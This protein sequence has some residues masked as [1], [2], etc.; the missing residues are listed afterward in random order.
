[1][2]SEEQIDNLI[3]E[4]RAGDTGV[5]LHEYLGMTRAEYKLFVENPDKYFGR[6]Q[7]FLSLGQDG[8]KL[9]FIQEDSESYRK[10]QE[11]YADIM[12]EYEALFYTD[13]ELSG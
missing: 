2:L 12:R 1:M 10:Y 5:P 8:M 11:E 6:Q 7:V 13:E 4:W 9:E 3:D